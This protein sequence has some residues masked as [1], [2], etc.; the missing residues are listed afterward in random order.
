MV[1]GPGVSSIAGDY[2]FVNVNVI[3]SLSAF[4]AG[5]DINVNEGGLLA[6]LEIYGEMLHVIQDSIRSIMLDLQ[7]TNF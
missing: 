5:A 6:Q 4:G 1:P 7:V 2:D 3:D